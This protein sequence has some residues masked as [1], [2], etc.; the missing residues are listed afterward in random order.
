MSSRKTNRLTENRDCTIY[1]S[2]SDQDAH[3]SNPWIVTRPGNIHP[4]VR[5]LLHRALFCC[6]AAL[7]CLAAPLPLDLF[8]RALFVSSSG[9][10]ANGLK[11]AFTQGTVLP[12]G[13]VVPKR[14]PLQQ[15][16]SKSAQGPNLPLGAK[17]PPASVKMPVEINWIQL[18]APRV[19]HR[20]TK[21]APCVKAPLC[22][23]YRWMSYDRSCLVV[24]NWLCWASL[25][26]RAW[27][28]S[29]FLF[30]FNIWGFVSH[31]A[32]WETFLFK[33]KYR[34]EIYEIEEFIFA[35]IHMHSVNQGWG[36]HQIYE[37]EYKYEFLVLLICASPSPSPSAWLLHESEFEYWLMSAST[38]TRRQKDCPD[39]ENEGQNHRVYLLTLKEEM[40][41]TPQPTQCQWQYKK[42][43]GYN[44]EKLH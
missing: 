24:D 3:V 32:V 21:T 16:R 11:G 22:S 41:P 2:I 29:M 10:V 36:E 39:A 44:Y 28:H 12:A 1:L 37:Y 14:A 18:R 40:L 26:P 7:R 30:Y 31:V 20:C 6:S 8:H 27:R 33:N 34:Q 9:V 15:R 35:Y 23:V 4:K 17:L 43:S 42:C 19:S 13:G 25:A 5:L 38:S